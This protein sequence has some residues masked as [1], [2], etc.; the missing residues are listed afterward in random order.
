MAHLATISSLEAAGRSVL[1]YD[2]SEAEAATAAAPATAPAARPAKAAAPA[3]AA[4]PAMAAA[5]TRG[6]QAGG[7]SAPAASV[8][9]CCNVEARSSSS[10]SRST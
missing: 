9:Y 8:A 3:T 4:A 7:G 6:A 5:G 10:S 2:T 1:I